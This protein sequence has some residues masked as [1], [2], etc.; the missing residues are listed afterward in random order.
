MG[1]CLMK[2]TIPCVTVFSCSWNTHCNDQG[3]EMRGT[4]LKFIGEV[5]FAFTENLGLLT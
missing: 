4:D 3:I 5:G 2:Y 1:Q